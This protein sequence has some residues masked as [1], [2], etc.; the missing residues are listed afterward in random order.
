MF[1]SSTAPWGVERAN[2]SV[3]QIKTNLKERPAAG[4][5]YEQESAVEGPKSS[6]D[7]LQRELSYKMMERQQIE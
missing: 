4:Y 5:R 7:D 2:G 6:L 3:P 1:D